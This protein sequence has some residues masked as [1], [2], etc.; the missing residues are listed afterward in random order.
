[1]KEQYAIRIDQGPRENIEDSACRYQLEVHAPDRKKVDILV[2]CDGVGGN[3]FGEI[4]SRE[5]IELVCRYFTTGFHRLTG[6][7]LP[8]IISLIKTVL[9][10]VNDKILTR[11]RQEPELE[12]MSTTI[13]LSVII[14][15]TAYV[16]WAGDSRCYIYSKGKLR[17]ITTDHTVTQQL[18]DQGTLDPKYA[19]G[20]PLSHTITQHIAKP[21]GFSPEVIKCPLHDGDL[22]ML[23]SDGLTDVVSDETIA[24]GLCNV[25]QDICTPGEAADHFIQTATDAKTTDN[26]TVVIY[27]HASSP[28]ILEKT[29]TG[30]YLKSLNNLFLTTC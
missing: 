20:H 29:R 13:V 7:E 22:F 18:V 15:N 5:S 11:S 12:G 2:V 1:M 19:N 10:L 21:Q 28:Q 14:D 17:R 24:E 25:S 9:N 30:T 8:V 4:A 6:F 27:R 23:C 3:S 16:A 26:T